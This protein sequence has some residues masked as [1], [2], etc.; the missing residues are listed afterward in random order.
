MMDGRDLVLTYPVIP[1]LCLE[2]A[3]AFLGV[4][5]ALMTYPAVR[6][7]RMYDDSSRPCN[8]CQLTATVPWQAS[9]SPLWIVH[10]CDVVDFFL[11]ASSRSMRSM[12]LVNFGLT[13][14]APSIP[15][16]TSDLKWS[17]DLT[18][19]LSLG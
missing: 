14:Q 1:P 12:K 9:S 3:I 13:G 7:A 5:R 11:A 16:G 18:L 10:D 17:R 2:S 4:L 6:A 8:I 19:T 15:H